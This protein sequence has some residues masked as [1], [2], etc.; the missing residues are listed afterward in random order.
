[1]DKIRGKPPGKTLGKTS[2]KITGKK[3]LLFFIIIDGN[4]KK[5]CH[6]YTHLKKFFFTKNYLLI[7]FQNCVNSVTQ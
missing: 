5:N 7:L 6:M 3:G 1:M 4:L 2:S